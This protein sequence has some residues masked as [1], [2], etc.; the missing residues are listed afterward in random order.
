M[1]SLARFFR[2]TLLLLC[3]GLCI[4]VF[5]Q[6]IAPLTLTGSTPATVAYDAGLTRLTLTGTGFTEMTTVVFRRAGYADFDLLN[7][8]Y[9]GDPTSM[10]VS[11]YADD[12]TP[13]TWDIVADDG[14]GQT[15]TLK[16]A[17]SITLPA[18]P[19][20]TACNPPTALSLGPFVI[21]LGCT[22]VFNGATVTFTQTGQLPVTATV[23]STTP[24][25]IVCSAT[26][27]AGGK[28]TA[29]VTNP[30]GQSGQLAD[31]LTIPINHPPVITFS[32]PIINIVSD[33][34]TALGPRVSISDPDAGTAELSLTV[35]VSNRVGSV[36]L[37]AAAPAG[38]TYC[39]LQ[40]NV[41][42]A[43]ITL[44]GTQSALNTALGNVAYLVPFMSGYDFLTIIVNDM[45]NTGVG[46]AKTTSSLLRMSV[47][48]PPVELTAIAPA[49]DYPCDELFTI[50]GKAIQTGTSFKLTM[51]GQPDLPLAGTAVTT[52]Q[53]VGA[54]DLTGKTAGVWSV[55]ATTPDGKSA[56]LANAFTLYP[57][58]T[59]AADAY[60]VAENGTLTVAAAQGVLA[61]DAANGGTLKATRYSNPGHGT[62]VF[63]ADGSF[64]YTPTANWYGADSFTYV[65]TGGSITTDVITVTLTVTAAPAPTLTAVS[66]VKAP[67]T[68]A[69]ALTLTGTNF[70]AGTTAKL[71]L[72]GQA[73]IPLT[74]VAITATQ[75]TGT[76]ALTGKA[77]GAWTVVVT[78]PDGQQAQLTGGFTVQP[79]LTVTSD[80]YTTVA[81]Q[82]LTIAAAQGVLANDSTTGGTLTAAKA[83]NPSHG[84]VAVATDGSF[85]YNATAGYTGTD[86]FTY[87]ASAGGVTSTSVTVTLTVKAPAPTVTAISPTTATNIGAVAL[88]ITGTNFLTGATAQCTQAGQT[89]V[90]LT[91]PV[92]TATKI[93]GTVTFAAA[94]TWTLVVTN[95]DGQTARLTNAF[96]I[97]VNQPPVVTVTGTL[98]APENEA[99][100][101]GTAVTVTDADAGANPL[102]VTLSATKGKLSLAVTT[103]VTIAGSGTATLTLTGAQNALATALKAVTYLCNDYNGVD[104]ITVTANDQGNTGY[105]GAKTDTKQLPVT[106]TG[107][108]P[109]VTAVSPSSYWGPSVTITITGTGFRPGAVVTLT[110][111]N[112]AY[113]ST[114]FLAMKSTSAT[115]ITIALPVM[116]MTGGPYTVRVT[117]PDGLF[118]ELT[119]GFTVPINQA[120]VITAPKSVTI[121]EHKYLALGGITISDADAGTNNLTV[122]IVAVKGLFWSQTPDGVS[123][124]GNGTHAVTIT[125]SQDRLAQALNWMR[126][127]CDD[128]YGADTITV[129][130]SDK[131]STGY[132]GAKITEVTIPVTVTPKAP[133][134][135][136]MNP[137]YGVTGKISVDIRG[138][139]FSNTVEMRLVREG[140]QD[141]PITRSNIVRF[142]DTDALYQGTVDVTKKTNGDWRVVAK[143]PDGLESSEACL[144]NIGG[145]AVTLAPASTVSQLTPIP[146]NAS[147][148]DYVV[149]P[150]SL[151]NPNGSYLTNVVPPRSMEAVITTRYGMLTVP[152]APDVTITRVAP[153]R[154][155]LRGTA[156]AI[157]YALTAATYLCDDT[158]LG[159]DEL[160]LGIN[161]DYNPYY[162]TLTGVSKKAT[163]TVTVA[164]Q[165]TV[166]SCSPAGAL[167]T[168]SVQLTLDGNYFS[169]HQTLKLV[170]AG[171]P[172]IPITVTSVTTTRL[173]G[174][175]DLTGAA[176]GPRSIAITNTW[177]STSTPVFTVQTPLTAV[178][179][180]YSVDL[181]KT[182]TVA[183]SGVLSGISYAPGG[184]KV[185]AW[186]AP[187]R[188]KITAWAADGSFTYQAPSNFTGD[189]HVIVSLSGN[190]SPTVTEIVTITVKPDATINAPKVT[191]PASL[192]ATE[193]VYSPLNGISISA[194]VGSTK[195][196]KV[197]LTVPRGVL[198]ATTATGVTSLTG[199][200]AGA[201]TLQGT[202]AGINTSLATLN[203][204]L[205]DAYG[206]VPLTVA[207]DDLGNTVAGLNLTATSTGAITVAAAPTPTVLSISPASATTASGTITV[208]LTGQ[209]Y[210][211]GVT[212]T[213]GKV[214]LGS[215]TLTG[216]TTLTGTLDMSKVAAGAW[217]VAV[218]NP[219]GQI[220]RLTRGFIAITPSTLAGDAY[221]LDQNT[222]LTVAAPGVMGNDSNI[223]SA[224]TAEVVASVTRGTLTLK[225]DGAFTYTPTPYWSGI[226]SFTY[227]VVQAGI[228]TDAATVTLT[229]RKVIQPP[230]AADMTIT[231]PQ[232][233]PVGIALLGADAPNQTGALTY[234]VTNPAHGTLTGTAPNLV[235]TPAESYTG[236][237]AFTYVVNNGTKDSRTATVAITVTPVPALSAVALQVNPVAT[238][239]P[240]GKTLTLTASSTGGLN[241]Y[242]KFEI[243]KDNGATWSALPGQ[244]GYAAAASYAWTPSETGTVQLRVSGCSNGNTANGV[245]TSPAVT[246]KIVPAPLTVSA[247]VTATTTSYLST[248]YTIYQTVTGGTNPVTRCSLTYR[249]LWMNYTIPI[250]AYSADRVCSYSL[251]TGGFSFVSVTVDA[252]D[253]GSSADY[254]ARAVVSTVQ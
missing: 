122:D 119:S 1:T 11:F 137:A 89:A 94:G 202:V 242:Y 214:A 58:F 43:T 150:L 189:D 157:T 152:N 51:A 117:N 62:L 240:V 2:T 8:L 204:Q 179:H 173:T 76:A 226:D 102:K 124:Q 95:P 182:L 82:T 10:T 113:S 125:A 153:T 27:P 121:D 192:K 224:C 15:V 130:V 186:S 99:M 115:T 9:M 35:Q 251:M 16:N 7:T 68:G 208:T 145:I 184:L 237:D 253:A 78:L 197:T 55:V 98:A 147:V 83:S 22:N 101:L 105:G 71:T 221:T 198:T 91:S 134:V 220:G 33:T 77:L 227:R 217:D 61:N 128:G 244:T 29:V 158:Y 245:K 70:V 52:T 140:G 201:I 170:A 18:A 195:P 229:V 172:D 234:R 156:S 6:D 254:Q 37:T 126:Y 206:T 132:G 81:G 207:I 159:S 42:A 57:M 241:V 108:A 109:T 47:A 212:A 215:V 13:G 19:T 73:D 246:C 120:P 248:T 136:I 238:Q 176:P 123:I 160:T 45:G 199:S 232:R 210:R 239:Y 219:D 110:Q 69:V 80:A 148:V 21:T 178:D 24:Q 49:A 161:P 191:L 67:N 127:L 138:S 59:T 48:Y 171:K 88:T 225:A 56:T 34:L 249:F 196:V 203:Y 168:G 218:T 135:R 114:S 243:S 194:G 133:V 146:L 63:N 96:N 230:T 163:L 131:G 12:L 142:T 112:Y 17:L 40:P 233:Q 79:A 66:P 103:G 92:V 84:T 236:A 169:S 188:G 154:I 39:S 65:V 74:G 25:A 213:V 216:G 223:T 97:P 183:A 235:Y 151:Y 50:T 185:T 162:Y 85:T 193:N 149:A 4:S 93:T 177:T 30:D 187:E 250:Q 129:R 144:F 211:T 205:L 190:Y 139:N 86:S 222:T 26:F 143:N 141:I 100:P 28:W 252:K 107:T 87:T 5:A 44:R 181:A 3:C 41:P 36:Q 228:A 116:N 209:N 166:A 164:P 111:G 38:I 200:G 64:T 247:R 104:A 106:V 174:T 31:A 53:F 231:T 32:D 23:I 165:A 72:A 20:V 54:V 167:N 46:G 75:I 118:G 90:S 60:T 175:A 180:A 14:A 155:L